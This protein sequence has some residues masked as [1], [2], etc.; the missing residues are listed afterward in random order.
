M[1]AP[2]SELVCTDQSAVD[3]GGVARTLLEG[4]DFETAVEYVRALAELV[5]DLVGIP[6][7]RKGEVAA[8]LTGDESADVVQDWDRALTR[9]PS[10]TGGAL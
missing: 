3:A 10:A 2:I 1:H 5:S 6:A 7:D 4:A 8:Y 9:Q